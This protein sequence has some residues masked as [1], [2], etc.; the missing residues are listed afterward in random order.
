M[1]GD[2]VRGKVLAC[3]VVV[4][5]VVGGVG[6]VG[7]IRLKGEEQRDGSEWLRDGKKIV[8]F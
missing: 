5:S 3:R 2:A 6:V 4:S 7:K 1:S 8:V